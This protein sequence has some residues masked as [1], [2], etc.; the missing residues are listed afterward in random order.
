MQRFAL[1]LALAAPAVAQ[2]QPGPFVNFETPLTHPI[3]VSADGL[4][5]F[6]VHTPDNRLA[7]YSLARPERPVL[8]QEIPVGLEP[9]SVAPR[10][11]DEVWVVNRLGD[12]ISVVSVS[13]GLVTATIR[14]KDEPADVV[15]AGTPERAFVSIAG[16]KEVRVFDAVS[17]AQVAV[18]PIFGEQPSALARSADGNRVWVA[19]HRSGNRTT[20]VPE[21]RAPL[22]PPPTNQTLPPAPKQGIIVD[23][24]DPQWQAAHGITLPDYDV[25]E[26]DTATL[27]VGQRYSG[28]GTTLFNI[29]V[30]PI[31]GELWVANTE[32]RNLVRFEPNLRGRL[33]DSRLTRIT[34]GGSPTITAFDL[35]PGINYTVLPNLT[36]QASALAQPTDLV[37]NATGTEL[38]VAAFGTDRIAVVDGAG[39]VTGFVELGA[40]GAQADPRHKRGP[41]GLALHPAAP[42]LYV[43]NRIAMTLAVIDTGARSLLREMPIGY[44]PTPAAIAE[45][46]GFLYDAKLSGN[47]TAACAACHVDGDIDGLGWDLGDPGGQMQTVQGL[48]MHPMKGPMTTQTLRGLSDDV[49]PFH[50]RGDRARLQDFNPA[51]DRLMGGTQL[52]SAD[53]DAY[54]DFMKALAFPPNPNQ[55]LDRTLATA[56]AGTSAQEGFV[57]FTT[58]PFTIGLTCATCH[59]LPK[60]TNSLVIA[61]VLLQEAQSFKVPQLRSAYQRQGRAPVGGL[62]TSGFGLLHDG[63]EN[64]VF[65]LLSR[66]VFQALS[67]QTA[68]KQKLQSYVLSFDTGTAPTIGHAVTATAANV[69]SPTV[70]A[71]LALLV[72]QAQAGNCDLIA[73]GEFRGAPHG[74]HFQTAAASFRADAAAL[75]S[76]TLAQLQTEIA[77][78][79]DLTFIGVPVGLGARIGVDRDVDATLDADEAPVAYGQATPACAP[80]LRLSGNSAPYVGNSLF[81]LVAA[82]APPSA[83]GAFLVGTASAALPLRDLTL[84]V[85]PTGVFSLPM[86]A[87]ATG[88][89]VAELPIPAGAGLAGGVV[90]AQVAFPAACGQLGLALS[91]GLRITVG[92]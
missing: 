37:F 49:A 44:D 40:P 50:W 91:N 61:N 18:V 60:G 55:N 34:P 15:F 51:F 63:S 42:R 7:V 78:G 26:I 24:N 22:P 89:G 4:R 41:R 74:F 58:T 71:D 19:A 86:A 53:M 69:S 21:N 46:R 6:A 80:A 12:S 85:G 29:A 17:Q 76:F 56:P 8:L 59:A 28:V 82:N 88:T 5:L 13:Q 27:A 2:G 75:G 54:A 43:H 79:A 36:A 83:P 10:T 25:F 90:F 84:L 23:S 52:S 31:S 68:N 47:G 16:G 39:Q 87:D 30:H 32:A 11:A 77:A 57:F 67:T 20:I 81:A 73:K 1:V 65:N 35:N 14:A 3:A 70:A 45:G 9:V 92:S 33:A 62:S 64:S 72:Q 48:A 66:P 38:W